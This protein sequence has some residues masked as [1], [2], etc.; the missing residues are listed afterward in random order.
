MQWTDWQISLHRIA[1][2]LDGTAL[3]DMEAPAKEAASHQIGKD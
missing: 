3:L 1:Y 2:S